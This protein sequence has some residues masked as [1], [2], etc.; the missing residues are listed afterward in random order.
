MLIILLMTVCV[1]G[2]TGLQLYWNYQNYKT[3]VKNFDRDINETFE[4]AVDGEIDHRHSQ[5]VAKFKTWLADTSFVTITCRNDNRENRTVFHMADTH[6]LIGDEKGVDLGISYFHERLT[7]ITPAAKKIFINHFG[8]NIL[9]EDL[10]KGVVYNYTQ[11]LGDSLQAFY[12]QRKLDKNIL[13]NLYQQELSTKN[14]DENFTLNPSISTQYL[15][16]QVNCALRRPYDK[17]FVRAGFQSPDAYFINKMK[18]LIFTSLLLI[19]ITLCCYGY[20]VKTLLSQHQLAIL[21]DDFINN[22]THEVNTPLASINIT[23]EALK[24]FNHDRQTQQQYLDIITYQAGKLSGLTARILTA[25]SQRGRGAYHMK[26]IDLSELIAKAINDM[27]QQSKSA[28][29]VITC[30]F[31]PT[32]LKIKGEESDLIDVFTNILDNA[33]KY[34]NGTPLIDIIVFDKNEYAEITFRDNGIGIPAVYQAKIFERFF[35][36]PKGN[37]HDVKGY[38]LGLSYAKQIITQ[39]KGSISV[40]GNKP[41]GSI[42]TI[43]IPLI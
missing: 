30:H 8:D 28:N 6:P 26:S 16:R 34:N 27:A 25:N 2:I 29:A 15:T 18:W 41:S 32:P 33:L 24:T 36:I 19:V 22:M 31:P 20:T 37:I 21:K 5:I 3:T 9:R 35:R 13:R 17:E 39:H 43:Q 1:M 11:K 23:A 14:I 7:K 10:R 40:T 12:E 4:A 38:G 42:F